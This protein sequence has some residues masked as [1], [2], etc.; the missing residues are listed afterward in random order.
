MCL[1]GKVP[2]G[3]VPN[4]L[5]V[6]PMKIIYYLLTICGIVIVYLCLWWFTSGKAE[7]ES[8]VGLNAIVSMGSKLA[9][10]EIRRGSIRYYWMGE[11]MD[12]T[13]KLKEM[14]EDKLR[15]QIILKHSVIPEER[16][17]KDAYNDVIDKWLAKNTGHGFFENFALIKQENGSNQ[18]VKS[19]P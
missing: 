18:S 5:Y 11:G 9:T 14:V 8:K 13:P 4:Y 15:L 19:S 16:L 17:W 7:Y 3:H 1:A 6:R 2:L 10:E 12:V